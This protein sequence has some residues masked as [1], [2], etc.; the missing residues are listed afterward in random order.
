[1]ILLEA[2]TIDD[3]IER[4][5]DPVDLFFGRF[6]PPHNAHTKTI[7]SLHNGVVAV[8]KGA[9]TSK[10]LDRNPLPFEYQK[11]L[12]KLI[13]PNV[14]VIEVPTGY[15]PQIINIIRESGKE[16][17]DV[18]AGDDR[19]NSYRQQIEGINKKLPHDKQFNVSFR[20]TNT[21]DDV[22]ATEVREAIRSDNETAFRVNTPKQI[23]G[24][25]KNL[26]QYMK[27]QKTMKT[28]NRFL[29][30]SEDPYVRGLSGGLTSD[31]NNSGVKPQ[32][33]RD[34]IL[35]KTRRPQ[36]DG[37]ESYLQD[38]G[39]KINE[40]GESVNVTTGLSSYV[41]PI[42]T[43][44]PTTKKKDEDLVAHRSPEHLHEDVSAAEQRFKAAAH[45][46]KVA[47]YNLE[48]A[49]AVGMTHSKQGQLNFKKALSLHKA[50][51]KEHERAANHLLK[52]RSR[53]DEMNEFNRWLHEGVPSDLEVPNY[54]ERERHY[55]AAMPKIDFD[56][57]K[58][59]LAEHQV[60]FTTQMVDPATLKPGQL[61]FDYEK[62]REI[63]DNGTHPTLSIPLIMSKDD[64]VVDGHHRW[65][66]AHNN[67][68][69]VLG[70]RIDLDF[71]DI[72]EFLNLLQYPQNRHVE[73][74]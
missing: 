24:E 5:N 62:V 48:K 23:W 32:K 52:A 35:S 53:V 73:K 36:V 72:I 22:S 3:V 17:R 2:F 51:S 34:S 9:A 60:G 21:R 45:S 59:D 12:I 74:S 1:M 14:D 69:P 31:V 64:V 61:N 19:I 4:K 63:Q 28:F 47:K 16:V 58:N 11:K 70:H 41:S 25:F 55:R 10:N 49:G 7:Q 15:L 56:Q 43:K 44:P 29:Q 18:W 71:H 54:E 26:Q 42:G 8:V 27:E 39:H 66:A 37:A 20:D 33:Q 67:G 13:S 40:D 6:Q 46:L 57:L 30:E 38:I 68:V 65:L 50:A